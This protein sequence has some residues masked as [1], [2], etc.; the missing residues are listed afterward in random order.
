MP[1]QL[2]SRRS[3]FTLLYDD[4]ADRYTLPV[5]DTLNAQIRASVAEAETLLDKWQE[6][7]HH[8]TQSGKV[9]QYAFPSTVNYLMIQYQEYLNSLQSIQQITNPNVDVKA[10]NSNTIPSTKERK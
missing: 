7:I 10:R 8:D 9:H 5:R 4:D 3:S 2:R 1:K 6:K